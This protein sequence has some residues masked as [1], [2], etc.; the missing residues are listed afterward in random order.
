MLRPIAALGP[1][2]VRSGMKG[3]TDHLPFQHAGVPSFNYDQLSRGY[4]YTHHSQ[5]DV[6]DYAVPGDISQAATVMAV[7][8]LQLANLDRLLPRRR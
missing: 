7:N 8:A 4:D 2:V 1:F 3:G 6:F 5:I